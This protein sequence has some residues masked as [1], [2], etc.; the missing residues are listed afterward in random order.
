MIISLKN[1]TIKTFVDDNNVQQDSSIDMGNT[2]VNYG[3]NLTFFHIKN[4][5]DIVE[6]F[7]IAINGD[8]VIAYR[9]GLTPNFKEVKQAS[10]TELKIANSGGKQIRKWN[11]FLLKDEEGRYK[12]D[13]KISYVLNGTRYVYNFTIIGDVIGI[14]TKYIVLTQNAKFDI[15]PDYYTAFKESEHLSS[16]P[17]QLLLN[18]KRKEFLINYFDLTAQVASYHTLLSVLHYFGYGDLLSIRELWKNEVGMRQSTEITTEVQDFI[19]NRL[20]GFKKTN[21]LQ[22]IYQINTPDGTEDSDGFPNYISVLFDTEEILIKMYALK[23]V[24][25]KDFLPLNTKIVDIIGQH[26]STL[27]VD[28]K[29]WLNNERID[30]VDLNNQNGGGF[31]FEFDVR[32]IE[33]SEHESLLKQKTIETIEST[34][35]TGEY[36]NDV[37]ESNFL[38][39]T[40]FEIDK[41]LEYD[42]TSSESYNGLFDDKD[43]V[44]RYDRS[45]FGLVKIILDADPNL[46]SRYRF[47]IFDVNESETNAVYSSQIYDIDELPDTR[48]L[49][50]GVRK[51]GTFKIKVYLFDYYGGV[52]WMNPNNNTFDVT[53]GNIDFKLARIDRSDNGFEKDLDI[54]STFPTQQTERYIEIDAFDSSLNVNTFDEDNNTNLVLRYQSKAYD[55]RTLQLNTFQFNNISLTDLNKTKLSDYGYEYGKFLVDVIGDG[56]QGDRTL[57]M[58]LFEHSEWDEITL[59]YS[60]D[61]IEFLTSVCSSINEKDESSIWNRFTA[62]IQTFSLD[63]LSNAKHIIRIVAKNIG[64]SIDSV[65]TDFTDIDSYEPIVN[66]SE[67]YYTIMPFSGYLRIYPKLNVGGDMIINGVNLGNVEISDL[68]VLENTIK[69]YFSDNDFLGGVWAYDTHIIVS[70]R[71]DFK[72]TH[73]SFGTQQDVARGKESSILKLVQSGEIFYKGEPFYAY[74]D[75]KTRLDGSDFKWTLTNA[76]NGEILDIQHSYVYRNMIVNSGSYSLT[77]ESVDMFGTNTKT[78]NGFVIVE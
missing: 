9:D 77:L 16:E 4:S 10:D 15:T 73:P 5:V 35:F 65:F 76:L 62:T 26:T 8:F 60:G 25:E 46:Y 69:Q 56:T 6:N 12:S 63:N 37:T 17:N 20:L 30:N 29:I 72:I 74:V 45:D 54:W 58:R 41:V 47:D 42:L 27:G 19:D 61:E 59:N 22:L 33:V 48:E 71:G 51:V 34:P 36:T 14:D 38:D 21:Q 55:Q 49:F 2:S 50:V 28:A 24:L 75:L 53:R 52:T 66:I 1:K 68:G 11:I 57:K 78:K 23:R 67:D 3:K 13:I 70:V 43:F 18:E 32:S 31:T 40:Y 44:E 64:S 7:D 39:T